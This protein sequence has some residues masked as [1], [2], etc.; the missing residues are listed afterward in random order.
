[1]WRAWQG[2]GL[3]ICRNPGLLASAYLLLGFLHWVQISLMTQKGLPALIGA[4]SANLVPSGTCP[5]AGSGVRLA[6]RQ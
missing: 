6:G 2:H 1:M 5:L 3:G 4:L